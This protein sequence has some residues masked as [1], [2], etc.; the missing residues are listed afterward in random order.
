MKLSPAEYDALLRR[1]FSIFVE[2]CFRELFPETPYSW[3]WHLDLIADKLTCVAHG[4]IRRL[5]INLPPRSLKSVIA[6]VALPAW[7]LGNAPT[8]DIMCVSYGQDLSDKM[9]TDCRQI[10]SSRW[11][12]RVF[13]FRIH[14]RTS[15]TD[16]RTGQGGGRF[17]TSVGGSVTGRGAD[18][19]IIDDP[20][21]PA[22][23]AS[24]T[25]RKW[26]N[27]WYSNT[28]MSRLNDKQR[29]AILVIMQRVH[30]DDPTG[31]LLGLG[32][33]EHLSLPAIAEVPER[34]TIRTALE[35]YT[36]ERQ[37]G[38]AL[39]PEREPLSTLDEL[40][41]ALGTY[42]FAGQYQ[43]TPVPPGGGI[44][45]REWWQHYPPGDLPEHFTTVVQ[46]WD[47]ANKKT[48]LNNYSVCTTWGVK[49]KKYYLLHVKR[50]RLEYPELKRTV[51]ALAAQFNATTVLI[52]DRASG[53]QLIQEL[54]S[55]GRTRVRGVTPTGD[56][57][58]RMQAQTAA[59]EAGNVMLPVQAPWLDDYVHELSVFPV[60]KYDDQVDSTSQALEW[61]V[62]GRWGSSWGLYE[63]VRNQA[64]EAEAQRNK[65]IGWVDDE[66]GTS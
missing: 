6:S 50:E 38:D 37:P 52:E 46:S 49:G 24:D 33:W 21:K 32:G 40:R 1:D 22:D 55:E 16:L 19:I 9:A 36:V 47:T 41:K 59:I 2:R 31:H 51:I 4:D 28:L 39:H 44:V 64:I 30:L 58:M 15:I 3:T 45:K 12:E 29:G 65:D 11:Y 61:M 10:M 7:I 17:A 25:V 14:A 42:D 26:V 60:G 34:H 35:T 5:I 8:R 63:L 54:R 56:K 66:A 18:L 23:A 43:Q 62:L 20:I 57:V 13:G 48:E 27:E 53:V